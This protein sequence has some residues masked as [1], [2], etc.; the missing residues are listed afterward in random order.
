MKSKT[1]I[2]KTIIFCCLFLK[3]GLCSAQSNNAITPMHLFLQK[4]A[5]ST[6]IFQYDVALFE[7]PIYKVLSKKG[8]TISIYEYKSLYRI[9]IAMPKNIR[10]TLYRI[11][12]YMDSYKVDINNFFRP[13]HISSQN[14]AK[15]W[16]H[17]RDL[18]PWQI[19]DDS[20]DGEGCPIQKDGIDRD[21]YDGGGIFVYL[22]TKGEIKQLYFY[23]PS[24]YEKLCPGRDG[25]KS[26]L[27][28]EKLFLAYFKE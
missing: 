20:K 9:D 15:F 14:S 2:T 6:V 21:I 19:N 25:R 11:N 5:D 24:Y 1:L 28:L 12:K 26:I 22:I 7:P 18:K 10:D 3:I 27:K 16:K 8:D 23:A 13:K 4:N 17:I